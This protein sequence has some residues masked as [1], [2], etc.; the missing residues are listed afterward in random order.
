MTLTRD[1]LQRMASTTG[2]QSGPLEKVLR[3]MELL[4]AIV[5]HPYLRDRVA[6][7]G[8]TALNLFLF[9]VPRLS[10][11]I[12]LNYVGASD[13]AT[14]RVERPL[15]EQAI[16]AVCGRL[17]LS[18]RRAPREHAGGKWRFSYAAVAG[19][20]GT[21]ELDVT[22]MLRTPLW[23]LARMDSR[24]VASRKAVGIP[25]LDVHELAAGKLAALVARGAS[26]DLFDACELLRRS[27]FDRTRLRLAFV[28]YGGM[29]PRDWRT[30]RIEDVVATAADVG[31]QLVPMLRADLAP[32][33]ANLAAWTD[34]LVRECQ[35]LLSAVLPLD[36]NEL[37]FL[38]KLN[39]SGEIAPEL[40]T[41]N[42]SLQAIIR[43]HPGLRWKAINVRRHSAPLPP[44]DEQP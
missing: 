38:E 32:V 6:L 12:D 41:D 7:K 35:A 16:E 31:S 25:V 13:L 33:R 26:R 24:L 39:G 42:A 29:N 43:D 28:V 27:D 44:T 34:A 18:V 3:L 1:E 10:V 30:L 2:F 5:A 36:S 9:D 4:E 17:D 14:M 20:T 21:L 40:L 8:G 37:A 15:L 19:G 11:D 22:F 23:P